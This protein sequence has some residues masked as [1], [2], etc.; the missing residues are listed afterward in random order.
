M[1]GEFKGDVGLTG[2]RR[3]V[4]NDLLLVFQQALDVL[5]VFGVPEQPSREVIKRLGF[6]RDRE[7]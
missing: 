5:E 1:V 3:A 4:E 2:S 7:C 6:H